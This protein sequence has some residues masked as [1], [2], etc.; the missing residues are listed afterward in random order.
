M[1]RRHFLKTGTLAVM[2]SGLVN[3]L[4]A[5]NS[6]QKQTG[7]GPVT[8]ENIKAGKDDMKVLFLGTGAAG[9]KPGGNSPRR[10]SSILVEDKFLIDFTISVEDMLPINVHPK[11]IFY[12]H[13]HADHYQ[14]ERAVLL[15]VEKVFL[16]ETWI[17]RARENFKAA[18]EKTGKPMPEIVPLKLNT[19]VQLH[20]MTITPLAANHAT[21]DYN[22]QTLI[23]LIEK[24]TTEDKLGVRLLY[25]TDTGGIMGRASRSAGIDTHKSLTTPRAITAFV[26]ESTMGMGHDEDYRMFNHSSSE[27]VSRITN[28]L[29]KTQRYLPPK[30]QPVY[31]THM[32]NSLHDRKS[33]E[34]INQGLPVP[35]RAAYDGLE[36]VFKAVENA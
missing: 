6:S 7:F 16:S 18:S 15:G 1:N 23:Y 22:E 36:V 31:I 19:P 4:F 12:T 24:G 30:G 29:I 3:K 26:M 14:P 21:N 34:E 2:A 17:E 11:E 25:A 10:N 8:C 13:S 20:G 28:M 9:W 5:F 32:S 27:V 33:Q 35:L